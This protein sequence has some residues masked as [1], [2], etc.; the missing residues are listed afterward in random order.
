MA[1]LD[2]PY[3]DAWRRK[4]GAVVGQPNRSKPA[5]RRLSRPK[6]RRLY[7]QQRFRSKTNLIIAA[8]HSLTEMEKLAWTTFGDTYPELDKYGN[9]V[10]IN[11]FNW[12]MRCN[13]RLLSVEGDIILTPP[14]S[15]TPSFDP[16][17]SLTFP[18]GDN[19][20]SFESSPF[21]SGSEKINVRRKINLSVGISVAPKPLNHFASF[22][23]VTPQPWYILEES[24]IVNIPSRAWFEFLPID[25]YGRRPSP[26]YLSIDI[27]P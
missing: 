1:I 22:G 16:T 24:E 26:T 18:N 21:P 19:S 10:E 2:E 12:F 6:N 8:W 13:K 5:A 20:V 9:L 17:I 3:W 23:F 15:S 11:G 7:N 25:F 27:E 4:H 14:P